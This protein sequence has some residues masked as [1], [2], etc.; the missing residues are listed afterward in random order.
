MALLL[1]ITVHAVE[2]FIL[3]ANFFTFRVWEALIVKKLYRSLPGPFYP[4]I[5]LSAIEKGGDLGHN[6]KFA[7]K[8]K[9]D[10]QTDRYGYRK[11]DADT[12]SYP[13]IIIG[14]SNIVG[15]PLPQQDTLSELLEKRLHTAIYP[16]APADIN[17]FLYNGRF[18]NNP[19]NIIILVKI[20]REILQQIQLPAVGIFRRSAK[21]PVL[22]PWLEKNWEQYLREN[23]SLAILIDRFLKQNMI[24]YFNSR[25]KQMEK[26]ISDSKE[27]AF[28]ESSGKTSVNPVNKIL[29]YPPA[30]EIYKKI[31]E[32]EIDQ[33]IQTI[34]LYNEVLKRM[35][36]RF[37]FV[38]IPNKENIFYEN[39]PIEKP[40]FLPRLISKLANEGVEVIDTQTAFE[41]AYR[42][43]NILL[44]HTDDTHWNKDG[45]KLTADLIERYIKAG[46]TL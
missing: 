31:S 34:K 43:N 16:L 7:V 28:I 38:P 18:T 22:L 15:G 42:K 40:M 12:T 13:I 21:K 5:K 11:I 2:L 30:I 4:S 33:I 10:W 3:P 20:E 17:T 39:V 25:L 46:K 19:P 6:T 27:T 23:R 26:T 9:V 45:V 1:I 41:E 37:I 35:G 24:R 44:F 36:I 29:F 8:K 14:D 32:T